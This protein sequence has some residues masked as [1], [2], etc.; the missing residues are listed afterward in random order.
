MVVAVLARAATTTLDTDRHR[1]HSFRSGGKRFAESAHGKWW[2]LRRRTS[3]GRSGGWDRGGAGLRRE[4]RR[5]EGCAKKRPNALALCD[6]VALGPHR[7]GIW[8]DRHGLEAEIETLSC[9]GRML[10]ASVP[11]MPFFAPVLRTTLVRLSAPQQGAS[12]MV[13]HGGDR[14]QGAP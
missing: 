7:G 3:W 10:V 5:V 9:F 1:G 6:A 4:T 8:S 11:V 2:W 14:L 12:T 13:A